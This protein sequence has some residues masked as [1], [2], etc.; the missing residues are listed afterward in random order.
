MDDI[1]KKWGQIIVDFANAK[2]TDEAC[3]KHLDHMAEFAFTTF[4]QT[5]EKVKK[6]FPVKWK[7]DGIPGK[8]MQS[9]GRQTLLLRDKNDR[10]RPGR[11]GRRQ[12][13]NVFGRRL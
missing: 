3:L 2:T 13:E 1:L 9:H 10:G 7:R 8:K 6:R 12:G 11:Y 5:M 4:P